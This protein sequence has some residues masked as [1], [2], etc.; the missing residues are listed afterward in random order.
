M[1]N[2]WCLT[3]LC[4]LSWLQWSKAQI[5]SV[6][7]GS[8]VSSPNHS[9]IALIFLKQKFGASWDGGNDQHREQR[10]AEPSTLQTTSG[11]ALHDS[12]KLTQG[13]KYSKIR[14]PQLQI[15]PS[16]CKY[17]A[18]KTFPPPL[19]QLS[20]DHILF[21]VQSC[22]WFSLGC[23]PL[24]RNVRPCNYFLFGGAAMKK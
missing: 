21:Q 19:A 14:Q 3:K 20:L 7:G 8:R 13:Q 18:D 11:L 15:K 10:R 4:A 9:S 23:E 17:C 6:A 5:S 12:E 1:D 22:L 24:A 16:T 2:W